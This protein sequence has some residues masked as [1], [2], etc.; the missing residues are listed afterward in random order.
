MSSL[1]VNIGHTFNESS[2]LTKQTQSVRNWVWFALIVL[3]AQVFL[4]AWVS[5]NYAVLACDDFPLCDGKL[6]PE[7]NFNEGFVLWR[8]LGK[9]ADG[10]LLGIDALRAIH[11]THRMGAIVALGI[12]FWVGIK[13]LKAAATVGS[14]ELKGWSVALIGLSFLQLI[15]GM[16]NIILD[17]PLI[18]ALLHTGGAAGLVVVLVRMLTLRYEEFPSV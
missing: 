8:E 4:G 17:W 6:I 1:S 7:M 2:Y 15:T 14:S 12:L 18:A 11:W 16:S 3:I 13:N 9:T 10:A 5:T